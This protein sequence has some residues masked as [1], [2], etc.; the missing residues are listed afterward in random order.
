MIE[1]TENPYTLINAKLKKIKME[2]FEE[3]KLKFPSYHILERSASEIKEILK[4]SNIVDEEF[5]FW[6]SWEIRYMDI[7][8]AD[9]VGELYHD[10]DNRLVRYH[11]KWSI[12]KQKIDNLIL[13]FRT[14]FSDRM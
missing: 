9:L 8:I 12:E 3:S 11:N 2:I 10:Y 5:E 13:N 6:S 14:K 1:K 7:F 4:K